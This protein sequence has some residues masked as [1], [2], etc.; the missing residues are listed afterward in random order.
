MNN[1]PKPKIS[2][3]FTIEDI[4]KIREWHYERRK[5]MTPEEICEDTRRGAE[6]A[7]ALMALPRDPVIKAEAR[8]R[9]AEA[10]AVGTAKEA[11][12]T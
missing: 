7:K 4:H 1:I 9:M 8:R 12:N 6:R 3:A 5:G 10:L 11:V 2:P